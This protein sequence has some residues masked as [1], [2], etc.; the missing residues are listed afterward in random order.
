MT[1]L[2]HRFQRLPRATQATLAVTAVAILV[3]GFVLFG[4]VKAIAAFV[5]CL[6]VAG[7]LLVGYEHMAARAQ[8]R[9]AAPLEQAIRGN[10]STSFVA[11]SEPAR[12]ARLDDLRRSF[13]SG[14][15]KFRDA[16]KNLYA[17]PWYLVVGEP[18][19]GKTEAIRHCNVGFP[20]GLQDQLQG[21]GGTLNMNWWFTNHAVMLDT[22]GRLMFEEVEPGATS[23]WQ[24]FLKLLR[25]SRPNCP[26]N[27]MLLVIPAESLVRDTA[28]AIERKGARIAQQLDQIQRALGVRFPVYVVVT[29]CDLLNGFREF[30]DEIADPQLQHQIMGWSNTAPLDAPFNPEMVDQHLLVVKRRLLRRRLGLLLDPINTEDPRQSRAA[31][32][33]AL[34]EFP[35]AFQDIAPRLKRYLSMIFVSGEWSAKPLF[36]RG[37]YFTSSMREGSVLDAKLAEALGVP[38]ESL[39]EGKVWERDRSYFLRD[40]FMGKVFRERGLVTRAVNTGKQQ[41]ARR[42]LVYGSAGLGLAVLAALSFLGHRSM[43]STMIG[44]T[45]F[46]NS[47]AS[48]ARAGLD[49]ADPVTGLSARTLPIVA[50]NA[51]GSTEFFYRG[52]AS[53]ADPIL[54]S[55]PIDEASKTRAR[56]HQEVRARIEQRLPVPWVYAPVAA[57]GGEGDRDIAHDARAEAGRALFESGILRALLDASRVRLN[58]DMAEKRAWSAQTTAALAQLL[59]A[60]TLSVTGKGRL[61]ALD[62]LL[63]F[64]L[65]T[66]D[67]YTAGGAAGETAD[68]EALSRWYFA[69][70][71]G[72]PTAPAGLT[73]L[74]ATE[75]ESA[76][77]AFV[78][79]LDQPSP[80]S[81]LAG[82][83]GLAL[84]LGE[85]D[86]A[87][88][89]LV[90]IDPDK[91][92]PDWVSEWK[93][94]FTALSE[95]RRKVDEAFPALDN[96]SLAKAFA[97]E[98]TRH[99]ESRGGEVRTLLDELK[100]ID[101]ADAASGGARLA[102]LRAARDIIASG[103]ERLATATRA[104]TDIVLSLARLDASCI[105]D[106][107]RPFYVTRH[108]IY[109]RLNDRFQVAQP[110]P[111]SP[112]SAP[113][114][115]AT[116]ESDLAGDLRIIED[117]LRERLG[118]T[119][120]A[121]DANTR[122][123]AARAVATTAANLAAQSR[124]AAVMGRAGESL[125]TTADAVAAAVAKS[126]VPR[127]DGLPRAA[128]LQFGA[129]LLDP[130]FD[131]VAAAKVLGDF[132]A[133]RKAMAQG[134]A[135]G[136]AAA[137]LTSASAAASEYLARYLA[138]WSS[139]LAGHVRVVSPSGYPQLRTDFASV[140]QAATVL[141]ALAAIQALSQEAVDRV[142]PL[143]EP[144]DQ[145]LAAA[146]AGARR[147]V[148]KARSAV[149]SPEFRQLC[150][151]VLGRWRA[152]SD[153]PDTARAAIAATALGP[154]PLE[155]YY[156]RAAD[157]DFVRRTWQS[158]TVSWMRT[159]AAG[160]GAGGQAP[161]ATLD[162]RPLDRFP[163][164]RPQ[165]DVAALSAAELAEA[166]AA[167]LRAP[168]AA[169][170]AVSPACDRPIS[171]DPEI[172]DAG[173]ALLGCGGAAAA[174]AGA[175]PAAIARM[176]RMLEALPADPAR[177]ECRVSIL[178][179]RPARAGARPITTLSQLSMFIARAGGPPTGK[180]VPIRAGESLGAIPMLAQSVLFELRSGASGD[181][182]AGPPYTAP[183]PW[184][185]LRLIEEFS[186]KPAGDDLKAW[187]VEVVFTSGATRYSMWLRLVFDQPLP[188]AP[189][190]R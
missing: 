159:L 17:L 20:P 154:S 94:R 139:D 186:G 180:T 60:Q 118:A 184:I 13:E 141:D 126:A 188:P 124:R 101:P 178:T 6:A 90:S 12:R 152:L 171:D 125:P 163:L 44:P 174:P 27:G 173:R 42:G 127:P 45:E 111:A 25:R 160:P 116:I 176:R 34:Y 117:E 134:S 51:R 98:L 137:R 145:T 119:R 28:D 70:A 107:G 11:I 48:T 157:D 144:S 53:P 153:N 108:A 115:L 129:G 41:A 105:G 142:A 14:L 185:P 168:T 5:A 72:A 133:V 76:A 71:D 113:P 78:E 15:Q 30:F 190:Y 26:V 4:S 122:F 55:L 138:H 179:D 135:G 29:K 63:R 40:L 175:A 149:E 103:A 68:L 109:S 110:D 83:T 164:N 79:S 189:W 148:A 112:A 81:G 102:A 104:Q 66:N 114:P 123:A 24:E 54:A 96:R 182:P 162:L 50:P 85:F 161:V 151:G 97:D 140:G 167:V 47:L 172:N 49:P 91:P 65:E 177:A 136:E 99:R 166:R 132:A 22:A 57:L 46:W 58:A 39:P 147:S 33:D 31:Q 130:R 43:S 73:Q 106:P 1:E 146:L 181:R 37:I 64:S 88:K 155:P 56:V 9:A 93:S 89:A 80:T 183:G 131:P 52:S 32:V 165:P 18:G 95:A 16:G 38:V 61:P 10:A 170:P 169:S 92:P 59:R 23:E 158:L 143:V 67:G 187:D 8:S 3:G 35:D 19:S 77:G 84:A 86:A 87:E 2:I 74:S 156:I 150:A 69:P 7:L 128:M 21:A 82:M 100:P 121:V 120:E 62:S 75:L 36:L